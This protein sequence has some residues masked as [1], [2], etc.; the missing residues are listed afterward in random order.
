M[1]PRIGR[2]L[3]GFHH[4]VACRLMGRKLWRVLDGRWAY[5]PLTEAIDGE[6][7]QEVDTYVS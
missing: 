5:T 1:S 7:L 2:T 6:G 4:R 3:G